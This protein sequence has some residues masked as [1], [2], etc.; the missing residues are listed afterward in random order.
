MNPQNYSP[1]EV[2]DIETRTEKAFALLK[3]LELFPSAILQQ[4]NIGDDTFATKVIC[5]LAD[6][7]FKPK[8]SPYVPDTKA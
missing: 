2:K 4:V 8:E 3:E 1:E 6:A 5:Y 7:K